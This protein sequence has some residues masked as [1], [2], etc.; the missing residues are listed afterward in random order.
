M[1]RGLL[2]VFWSLDSHEIVEQKKTR[3][4]FMPEKETRIRIYN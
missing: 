1:W 3:M 2:V 4:K